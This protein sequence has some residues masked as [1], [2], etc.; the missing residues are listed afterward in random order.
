M[1]VDLSD[2]LVVGVSSRA[3]FDLEEANQVF[4]TQGVAAYARYQMERVEEV[5]RPGAGFPLVQAL[6]ALNAPAGRPRKA[7]VVIMSRNDPAT[8]LRMFHSIQHHGLD[9]L[10]AAL[11]GGAGLSQYLHAF[12]VDLFLSAAEDDVRAALASGVAAAR[13]YPTP[14]SVA[15]PSEQIRIAFDA[16]AVLFS[17]ASERIYQ[18]RGLDAFLDHEK[19][20]A[21]QPLPEGPFAKLLRTLSKLQADAVG[22]RPVRIAVVS[23]RNMPAHERVIRTL[24]AWNVHVDEAFFMGGVSKTK[25]LEAF[26]PHIFFDDQDVH[27]RPASAVVPTGRVL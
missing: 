18:E 15:D 14:A 26:H 22:R 3:L 17:D 24:L 16:D 12:N 2:C 5:L 25:I 20:N 23:A 27:C 7:E 10:R 1:P 21:R 13:I 4:E 6:L 19:A 8:S 11:A 9:I